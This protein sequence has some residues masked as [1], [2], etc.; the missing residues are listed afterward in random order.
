MPQRAPPTASH[1][2]TIAPRV[3][4]TAFPYVMFSEP[5]AASRTRWRMMDT[6]TMLAI[7]VTVANKAAKVPAPKV[8]KDEMRAVPLR[9]LQSMNREVT[10]ATNARPA[11]IG[12]SMKTAAVVRDIK[13]VMLETPKAFA[14]VESKV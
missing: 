13:L 3:I 14:T 12:L 10:K 1:K 11:A 7:K 6:M 5:P 9:P 8:R 4:H 2:A